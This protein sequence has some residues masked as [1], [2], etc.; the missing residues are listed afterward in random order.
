M[1]MVIEENIVH[2][3]LFYFRNIIMLLRIVIIII[4]KILFIIKIL[5]N[6]FEKYL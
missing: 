1:F 3:S 5:L 2:G 4:T 6:F